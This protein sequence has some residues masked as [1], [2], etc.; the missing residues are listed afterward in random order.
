MEISILFNELTIWNFFQLTG[1]GLGFIL[2]YLLFRQNKN[3]KNYY[4][5]IIFLILTLA[6]L[7][8]Q[9]L[10]DANLIKQIPAFLY[11]IEPFHMLPGLLI[12]LYVRN[13]SQNNHSFSSKDFILLTPFLF[14]F[15]VYLPFYFLSPAEKLTDFNKFGGLYPDIIDN[16]WEWIFEFT[17]NVYFLIKALKEVSR[18]KSNIK[19]QLSDVENVDLKVVGFFI[20]IN[21]GIYSTELL[22]VYLTFWGFPYYNVLFNFFHFAEILLLFWLVYDG[23]V[24]HKHILELRKGWIKLLQTDIREKNEVMKYAKSALN[25]ESSLELQSRLTTYMKE[26]KPFLDPQLRIKSLSDKLEVPSHQ[27]SQVINERFNQNFYEFVNSHRVEEAKVLLTDPGHE[28][29]TL[30]SIGYEA[31]FN[32]KSAFFNAFKKN[33]NQ[34]PAQFKI[35]QSIRK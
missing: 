23:I 24:S 2:F 12:Y 18:Y 19:E 14:A 28:N 15:M 4:P 3:V 33:T 20:K 29:F 7:L 1:I 6:E 22:F 5:V 26:H 13:H 17:I 10:V 25:E 32:S 31:G 34:T 35:S 30:S 8:N 21:I 11:L 16:I 9:F 27:I